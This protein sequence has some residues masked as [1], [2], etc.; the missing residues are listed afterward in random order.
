[1][2]SSWRT[3]WDSSIGCYSHIALHVTCKS[4]W[5]GH[6]CEVLKC[7]YVSQ[8][9]SYRYVDLL[10]MRSKPIMGSLEVLLDAYWK[11]Y[12]YDTFM[13]YLRES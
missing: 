9:S 6:L 5:E 11:D 7:K 13:S 2:E 1:M 4:T 12:I 10:L 3:L 8:M